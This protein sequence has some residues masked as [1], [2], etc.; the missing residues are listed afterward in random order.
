MKKIIVGL[1]LI[2]SLF[3]ISACNKKSNET[4]PKPSEVVPENEI[5]ISGIKYVLNKEEKEYNMTYMV[6]E[7][8]TRIT[9]DNGIIYYSEKVDGKYNMSLKLFKHNNMSIDDAI[10]DS[11]GSNEQF[12]KQEV[13][14]NDI[15]YTKIQYNEIDLYFYIKDNVTHVFTFACKEEG[16]A[17][18]LA[19][20]F[21]KYV[22]YD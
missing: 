4:I 13:T 7:N 9:F 16:K 22:K 17:V 21:L 2:L 19:N 12:N 10:K 20:K 5:T 1:L 15:T 8:F 14:I 11:T 18:E 3:C 6:A